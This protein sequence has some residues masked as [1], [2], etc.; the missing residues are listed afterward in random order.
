MP[1]DNFEQA[2]ID[3]GYDSGALDDYVPTLNINT[4]EIL[5]ISSKHISDLTGIEDFA[6]LLNLNCQENSLTSLDVTKNI[7]LQK[8]ECWTNNIISVDLSQNKLLE[9][10]ELN[11][12]PLTSLDLTNNV[13]LK[14][15][16]FG[17]TSNRRNTISS[18][19]VSKNTELTL[20]NFVYTQINGLDL[21][22]NQNLKTLFVHNNQLTNIDV[23]QNPIL[24]DLVCNNNQLEMLNVKNGN[25]I[26]FTRFKAQVNWRLNCV[27]VDDSTWSTTNWTD[28]DNQVIFGGN[29]HY[30]ETYVPDDN[31]EQ[32][33]IDLGYDTG[34]LDDYVLTNNIK[35]VDSLNVSNRNIADITGLEDFKSLTYLNCANNVLT[36]LNIFENQYLVT[37]I[38]NHN[39]IASLEFLNNMNLVKIYC[40]DNNLTRLEYLYY[41]LDLNYLECSNNKLTDLFIGNNPNLETLYTANNEL[42]YLD[43]AG[44]LKLT[45]LDASQNQLTTLNVKNGNN[46]NFTEFTAINNS[47]L[48][49]IFV[50]DVTWSTANWTNIDAT[51]NFVADEAACRSLAVGD[52]QFKGFK[53][54]SNPVTENINLS[55]EEEANFILVDINGKILKKGKLTIG[56][57]TIKVSNVAKGLCFLKVTNTNKNNVVKI[58]IK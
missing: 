39:Q 44:N 54:L 5:D 9:E 56:G 57:N 11:D 33:L 2:L 29:C 26:N 49:C 32:A 24:T 10:L 4:I 15:V 35:Y 45:K 18:I 48:T 25:N 20:L 6:A 36:E 16:S 28:V 52:F 21:S 31:F 27:E 51:S 19:D 40:N 22:S 50:D 13:N 42:P 38:C 12:N 41:S 55:I 34:S 8:I 46:I 17:G 30:F 14:E 23:S 37:L 7:N 53:I 3:L 58:I 43:V 1:D 47:N